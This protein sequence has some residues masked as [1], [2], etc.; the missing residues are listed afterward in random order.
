MSGNDN[1]ASQDVQPRVLRLRR[2]RDSCHMTPMT[3]CTEDIA[4][5]ANILAV[6]RMD[7]HQV[8][9]LE[10]LSHRF[11]KTT[12]LDSVDFALGPGE[13]VALL[14]PNGARKT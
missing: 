5:R 11:G 6:M 1:N 3:I 14:G 7:E 12:A 8:A 10:Q 9:T 2:I 4:P 13:V